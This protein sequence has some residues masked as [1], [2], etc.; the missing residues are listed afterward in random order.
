MSYAK[1]TRRGLIA[2]AVSALAAPALAKG[3]KM[4]EG[5]TPKVV[6]I[7]GGYNPGEIH[8]QP[9]RFRLYLIGK[10]NTAIRYVVGV[11]RK[12]RYYPGTY[13]V[14]RKREWPSWT[15]TA[16]M[17]EREPE[18]Y[19]PYANGVK[20]G[21]GNPLGSRGIYLYRI[22]GGD[23]LLR[24]HGTPQPWTIETSISN[25]CVRLLNSH[26]EDL[27][28]RVGIGARVILHPKTI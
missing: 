25:G 8:V 27:Y 17:I 2:S 11:G 21:P 24:I 13:R 20:G 9:S 19:L 7:R 23:T 16:K 22:S 10:D 14:G 1:I 28:E 3:W 5:W 12:G 4:P 26:I 15:P 6:R 18:K